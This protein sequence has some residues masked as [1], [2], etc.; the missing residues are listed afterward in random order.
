[1]FALHLDPVRFYDVLQLGKNTDKGYRVVSVNAE[2]DGK[3]LSY[4]LEH[5]LGVFGT[6]RSTPVRTNISYVQLAFDEAFVAAGVCFA[7]H[8]HFAERGDQKSDI[9]LDITLTG[10]ALPT[11]L[12]SHIVPRSFHKRF[13][14]N[15]ECIDVLWPQNND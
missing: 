4:Q 1:M 3:S 13:Q 12:F 11:W 6:V 2:G 7:F 5:D 8:W 10:A 9:E 14:I 15:E